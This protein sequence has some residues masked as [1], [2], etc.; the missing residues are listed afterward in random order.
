MDKDKAM[1]RIKDHLENEDFECR[2]CFAVDMKSVKSEII[3]EYHL[4][5]AMIFIKR[6]P[7]CGGVSSYYIPGWDEPY[8][9]KII[10]TLH[11]ELEGRIDSELFEE[12]NDRVFLE[13]S[14]C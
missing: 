11:P 2:W 10:S 13:C 12:I 6:C 4:P 1:Q 8:L 3:A 9:K 14:D 7:I 5:D